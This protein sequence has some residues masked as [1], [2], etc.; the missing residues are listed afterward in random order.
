MTE[1]ERMRRDGP[2]ADDVQ[3]VKE[4]EK[5]ALETSYQQN[6]FWL[7]ALQT[8]QMLG[9]DPV[10]IAHRTQRT[11]TLT[12]E[13]IHDAFRKYFPADRYTVMTLMPEKAGAT[14]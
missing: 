9:W 13:N 1:L 12:P 6:G 5:E 11:D 2:S 14:Q 3:K 4:T 8:A 7:G 10:T